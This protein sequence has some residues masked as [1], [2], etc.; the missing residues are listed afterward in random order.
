MD[1]KVT[2]FV[3]LCDLVIAEATKQL[4]IYQAE[5]RQFHANAAEAVQ[6]GVTHLRGAALSGELPSSR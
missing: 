5:G 2:E 6:E 4:A 1:A 3:R